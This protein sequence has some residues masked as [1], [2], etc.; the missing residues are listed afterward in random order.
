MYS[1]QTDLSLSPYVSPH[2]YMQFKYV[3]YYGMNCGSFVVLYVNFRIQHFADKKQNAYFCRDLTVRKVG[4]NR[5][6]R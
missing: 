3:L 5:Y 4:S 1:L 2:T 6:F